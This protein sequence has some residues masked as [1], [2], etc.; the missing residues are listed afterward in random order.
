MIDE[1]YTKFNIE[2]TRTEAL[3]LAEIRAL[4][5][6]RKPL[7]AAGL[8]GYYDESGIGYGNISQRIS[9]GGQF[10]ISGTQTGHLAELGNEHFSLV[11]SYDLGSNKVACTGPIQASSESLTHAGIYALDSSIHAVVHIHSSELWLRLRGL[12]PTTAADVAY[13]TPEMALEFRRLYRHTDFACQGVA[14]MAGHEEG[15][16]GIGQHLQEASSRILALYSHQA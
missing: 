16:I 10:V 7:Y 8:I 6:W 5:D 3:Q 11:T 14:V 9:A 4:I 1:G 2:W 12:L 15:L 13:G